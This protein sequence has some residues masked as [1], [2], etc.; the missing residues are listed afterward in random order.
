MARFLFYFFVFILGVSLGSFLNSV[1][2]RLENNESFRG[3]SWCPNCKKKLSWFD[4]IPLFSFLILKGRCRHCKLA[5]SIQYP[6]VELS[7]GLLFLLITSHWS[8]ISSFYGL[9]GLFFFWLVSCF[10]LI[11]F[12]YDL[13][14]LI[15]PDKIVYPG[16]VIAFLYQ[17]F[18]IFDLGFVSD[19]GF[20]ISDL[21]P[22]ANSFLAALLVSGFF[23][24]IVLISR[25]K[26]MGVG[27]VKLA[28]LMGLL[29]GFPGILVALFVAFF[30]G[31]IIGLGLIAFGKKS[32]KAEV[33][34]GPFLVIGTFAQ[35]LWGDE[36]IIWYFNL[37][38]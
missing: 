22:L 34:F 11:I 5:I 27:D 6:L 23:L 31:A 21:K 25:G 8:P 18:G 37:L 10:L 12:V 35:L 26:W 19:F 7:T 36:I 3:R 15:I 38:L 33:P 9:G 14:H 29:L 2:Y 17:L 28:F 20:S 1:T 32:L 16:I 24:A 30:A 4:L 13:K